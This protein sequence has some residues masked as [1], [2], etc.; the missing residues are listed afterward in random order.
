MKELE[1][2]FEE[3]ELIRVSL[4]HKL[5]LLQDAVS[6]NEI[7]LLNEENEMMRRAY[8]V[9]SENYRRDIARIINLL[10]KFGVSYE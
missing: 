2:N 7:I 3:S 4:L 1:I 5:E 8:L 6:E 9:I 10:E